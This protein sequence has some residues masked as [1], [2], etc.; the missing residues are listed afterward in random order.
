M[1]SALCSHGD[2]QKRHQR[3]VY[4]PDWRALPITMAHPAA[5]EGTS[6]FA[7]GLAVQLPLQLAH[8]PSRPTRGCCIT[9]LRWARS[10]SHSP[11]APTLCQYCTHSASFASTT[12]DMSQVT[13]LIGS[14]TASSLSR[15]HCSWLWRFSSHISVIFSEGQLGGCSAGDPW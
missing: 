1:K 8:S 5:A 6:C 14:T 3:D 13:S 12:K 2:E 15:W 11:H 10:V 4:V 9:A 7:P